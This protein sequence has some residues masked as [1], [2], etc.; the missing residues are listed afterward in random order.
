MVQYPAHALGAVALRQGLHKAFSLS[1]GKQN[2][3]EANKML[4]NI[5]N[6]NEAN[7]MLIN[8]N[9]SNE[10]NK[11]LKKSKEDFI[12]DYVITSQAT[13]HNG[14]AYAIQKWRLL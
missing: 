13:F 14:L 2:S 1:G 8:I 4:I 7:K 10:A 5:N 12:Q 6:S 11:I 9:N 3:N